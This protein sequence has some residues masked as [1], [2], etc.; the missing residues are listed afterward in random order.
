MSMLGKILLVLKKFITLFLTFVA[1]ITVIFIIMHSIPGDPILYMFETTTLTKEQ[2]EA[3]RALYGFNKPLYQQYLDTLYNF[4]SFNFGRS[5]R[6]F[7][8]LDLILTRLPYTVE[9]A[10]FGL[11]WGIVIGLPVGIIS[12]FKQETLYDYS[13]YTLTLLF[14]SVPVFWS[15]LL[16]II[17]FAIN[18]GWFPPSHATSPNSVILP[19]LTLGLAFSGELARVTRSSIIDILELDYVKLAHAKGL[20]FHQIALKHVL[21]NALIPITT[22]CGMRFGALLAGVPIVETIFAW[23]GIGSLV[24]EAILARD[25]PLVQGCIIFMVFWF[26]LINSLVDISYYYLNP[27]LKAKVLF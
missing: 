2:I 23:P 27:K 10:I 12:A 26:I 7:S 16:L 1:A 8:V 4:L 3:L 18:L 15:G 22:L 5:T 14:I 17:I 11:L 19:S 20:P 21:R 25:I 13:L 9:L 24:Y 6:G